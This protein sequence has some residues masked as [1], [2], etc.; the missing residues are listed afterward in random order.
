MGKN[1]LSGGTYEHTFSLFTSPPLSESGTYTL[2]IKPSSVFS[3]SD[4]CGNTFIPEEISFQTE[5]TTAPMIALPQDTQLCE[6]EILML[7]A[8]NAVNFYEWQNGD[9]RGLQWINVA[10]HINILIHQYNQ[11]DELLKE[12]DP[13][14]HARMEE[15]SA[16]N[17]VY[18]FRP[19][20]LLFRRE[21]PHPQ[22]LQFW[23]M[24]W[25]TERLGAWI[26]AWGRQGLVSCIVM[27]FGWERRAT[28]PT[29]V[30]CGRCARAEGSLLHLHCIV[31]VLQQLRKTLMTRA[32]SMEDLLMIFNALPDRLTGRGLVSG[33]R[34]VRRRERELMIRRQANPAVDSTAALRL[35]V[36]ATASTRQPLVRDLAHLEVMTPTRSPARRGS[37]GSLTPTRSLVSTLSRNS[38]EQRDVTAQSSPG[39][40]N[41]SA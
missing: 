19:L 9:R 6:G 15:S 21:L 40:K 35:S 4:N 8:G 22:C 38:F 36:E 26:M 30:V 20:L 5:L 3:M 14:L 10:M 24:L 31:G 17:H 7:I 41:S 32:M 37:F 25:A 1:C 12:T 34:A 39:V 28:P 18:A 23:E 29:G 11:L 27:S 13:E 16:N 2:S 33:A